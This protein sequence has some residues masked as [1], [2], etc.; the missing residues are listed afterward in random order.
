MESLCA[1]NSIYYVAHYKCSPGFSAGR[2]PLPD[3]DK[4]HPNRSER[5]DQKANSGDTVAQF[6]NSVMPINWQGVDK[7]LRSDSLFAKQQTTV[8][9]QRRPILRIST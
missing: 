1:G 8:T 2:N 5:I 4:I 3:I 7:T 9:P 6:S